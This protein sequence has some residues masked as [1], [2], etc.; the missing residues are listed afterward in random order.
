MNRGDDTILGIREK[1]GDAVRCL[2]HEQD[3]RFAGDEKWNAQYLET[4]GQQLHLGRFST[5][6][7]AFKCDK[8][9]MRH[10][11]ESSNKD[12]QLSNRVKLKR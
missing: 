4:G 6:L 5:T 11:L 8:R 10:E 3:A 9:Q 7:R 1:D 12:R 2:H